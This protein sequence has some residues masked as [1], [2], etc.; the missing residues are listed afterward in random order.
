MAVNEISFP[1]GKAGPKIWLVARG[2]DRSGN[3]SGGLKSS[4]RVVTIPPGTRLFR[5]PRRIRPV[6]FVV[7]HRLGISPHRRSLRPVGPGHHREPG[8]GTV[9]AS[10]G[11]G[12]SFGMVQGPHGSDRSVHRGGTQAV[13]LRALWRGRCRGQRS[14]PRQRGF[15]A[16]VRAGKGDS[17]APDLPAGP[18]IFPRLVQRAGS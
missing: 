7:V 17:R 3:Q 8:L 11:L 15:R 14:R 18:R 10:C 12:A 4:A 1:G 5:T 9:G 6:R 16:S 13:L 2:F